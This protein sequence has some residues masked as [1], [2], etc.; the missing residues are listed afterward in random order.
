MRAL[1]TA[2]ALTALL[3]FP[4]AAQ[5]LRG[6]VVDADRHRPLGGAALVL[7]DTLGVPVDSG[8]AG[9]AGEFFLRAPRAG[10]YF[11]HVHLDGWAGV[12]SDAFLLAT[13]VDREVRV[14]VPLIAA[15][16]LHQ[17]SSMLE[18]EALQR[19]LEEICGE[20]LRP[21][22][23]GVLVGVVRDRRSRH[24]VAGARVWAATA[25]GEILRSTVSNA[26]GNYILC[27]LTA[28]QKV[29]VV[30]ETGDGRRGS[31][32]PEIRAG[33]TSWYDLVLQSPG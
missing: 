30:A 3:P 16:T 21:W 23:A 11:V 33:M 10:E 24:P 27:N 9:P 31:T 5:S 1:V 4:A 17:M 26:R 29:R 7:V 13:G 8:R 20:P 22:E 14:E 25:A 12:P 2:A 15:S 19:P 32:E 18:D 28:G 6:T